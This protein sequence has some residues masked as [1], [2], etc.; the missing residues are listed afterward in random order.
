MKELY[1]KD[2]Q[3]GMMIARDVYNPNNYRIMLQ[4]GSILTETSIA[5]LESHGIFKVFVED[6]KVETKIEGMDAPE[7]TYSEKL[8]NQPDF[9]AFKAAYEDCVEVFQERVE[10]SLEDPKALRLD[11]LKDSVI[12]IIEM[13]AV[14]NG[15]LSMMMNMR[16]YDD[17]VFAHSVNVALLCSLMS[18]WL[19]YDRAKTE[20]ATMCGLL[21]DIGKLRMPHELLN[22]KTPLTSAELIRLKKHP[23]EGYELLKSI[24]VDAHVRNAALMHHERIDGSGY[25]LHLSGVQIDEFARM[26]AIADVFDAMTSAR[27]NRK[28]I[29]PFKAM[30]RLEQD[31]Y[32]KYD[33]EYL[34]MFLEST[35]ESFLQNSCVLS[36]GRIGDIVFINRDRVSRPIVQTSEGYVNLAEQPD[37]FVEKLI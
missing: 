30:E 17:C 10:S 24:E 22:Q 33:V 15:V 36:D 19:R 5:H 2:L 26:V 13:C 1:L 25:P 21:H 18:K 37:L 20:T 34:L 8:K 23:I 4:Q 16:E 29:S 3:P 12:K 27:P 31:G 9:L 28:P 14:G 7:E 35:S 11:E 6:K 32:D